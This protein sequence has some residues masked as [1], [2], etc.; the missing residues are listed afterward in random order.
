MTLEEWE[1]VSELF[2]E[3]STLT[4]D[5]R[6][7]FLDEV[8]DGEDALRREVESLLAAQADAG[9]FIENPVV[10]GFAA[11]S[12]ADNAPS[13]AGLDLGHYRIEKKIGSGGM[14]DVYLSIDTRLNRPVA[15]KTLPA[16]MAGDPN[17]LKRF[18][19]EAHAAATLNHPNVAT[20][21]SVED[22]N[23]RPVITMEYVD[24]ST[25]DSVTPPEGLD[26]KVF[27]NWFASLADALAHAHEKGVIHRDIKPGNIMISANG[28]PKILDFG[29]AQI[30]DA[31]SSAVTANTDIT[32]PGQIIGTP[33]YMSPEQAEG[34]GLDGRSDIF[35]FGIVMYEAIT[36]RRPFAGASNAEVVSNLLKTDPPSVSGM[37]PQVPFLLS[38]LI[39]RCLNKSRRK[40]FQTM[41]EVASLL[42][43]SRT[44]VDAGASKDS[45]LRRFYREMTPS[46]SSKWLAAAAIFV[47]ITAV[48]ARFLLPLWESPPFVSFTN[49]SMHKLSQTAN[50]VYAHITPD[51]RSIIYNTIEENEQRALWIRRI[52]DR[53]SLQLLEPAAVSFWGG[54]AVSHDGGYIYYITA[55]RSAKHGTLFRIA[56]LGGQPRK[57]VDAVNDLG[58]LSA[59]GKRLFYVR[60]GDKTQILSAIAADGSDEQVIHTAEN[61]VLL[62]D[63]QLSSDGERI[64]FSKV[65][66]IGA[67]ELWSLLEI[68]V[69]GGPERTILAPRRTR[70]NEIAV[71]PNDSG[72]LINQGDPISN[73]NQLYFVSPADG[74]ETRITNDLNSHFGI[75]IS[76]DGTSIVSAQRYYSKDIWVGSPDGPAGF[77]KVTREPTVNMRAVWTPDGRIVYDVEDNGKTHI[78]ISDVEGATAQQLTPNDSSDTE[79]AVSPDG[80]YIVFTSERS[81]DKKI[82]R[83]N[84][85]GSDP[86]M[87]A[88]NDGLGMSPVF[89]PDGQNVIF[90]WSK[91]DARTLGKVPVKGGEPTEMPL[92]SN[93]DWA[94]S[95]DGR[96]VAYTFFDEAKR[97]PNVAIRRIDEPAPYMVLDISPIYILSWTTDD[98]GLLYRER[99]AGN[100]PFSTVWIHDLKQKEPRV[101]LSVEPDTVF[102]AVVS[103]NGKRVAVVRGRLFTDAVMLSR[104]PTP[105]SK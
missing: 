68:S 53:N 43:E 28:T 22:I 58:S 10:E 50:V 5:D 62:R 100:D 67:R 33:S 105:E 77:R 23:G 52:D 18:R 98:A 51:G 88:P 30:V 8:C 11:P 86:I 38:R 101:F 24:G 94:I 91:G 35:S 83:M 9:G 79:P 65:E 42:S 63:P 99:E 4:P 102:D 93:S 46:Q 40:R 97:R 95:H 39:E 17:L 13:L 3:A 20:I 103:S 45:S 60:Y 90:V 61:G 14:G 21:Y 80:K 16:T 47:I 34:K 6:R 96:Q 82:W 87:L 64:F 73:L 19:N 76:K 55:E 7:S 26:L 74:K 104:E 2:H 27:L 41:R 1:R 57:I 12:N 54:M 31:R 29:L 37:R 44:A 70:I 15:M 36:G 85:D 49:L 71:L 78:W 81:V 59:D 48:S 25:L 84:L 75:S 72:L 92:Y 32:Q 89:A 56:A 66:G 69:D